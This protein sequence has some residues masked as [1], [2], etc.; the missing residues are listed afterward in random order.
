MDSRIPWSNIK[1]LF[2]WC[3]TDTGGAQGKAID[4][5]T[6]A[7]LD[8]SQLQTVVYE[9]G[10][11]TDLDHYDLIFIGGTGNKTGSRLSYELQRVHKPCWGF[12]YG[13]QILNA[14]GLSVKCRSLCKLTTEAKKDPVFSILSDSIRVPCRKGLRLTD[15]TGI[16]LLVDE[17]GVVCAY[18]LA[19]LPVY[20][21][22]FDPLFE[23]ELIYRFIQ[24][25]VAWPEMLA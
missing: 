4:L 20:A 21:A 15:D 9:P 5:C 19:G 18:K 6:A 2:V 10:V 7:N 13:A 11:P 22:C 12:G 8:T 17:S 1:A 24:T 23:K 14:T 3:D 25:Y 16:S